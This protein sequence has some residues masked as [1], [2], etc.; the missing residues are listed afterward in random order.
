[1]NRRG[2]LSCFFT[3]FPQHRERLS[4]ITSFLVYWS[5]ICSLHSFKYIILH[6]FLNLFYVYGCAGQFYDNFTHTRVIQEEGTSAEKKNAP[7]ALV[8]RQGCGTF[9]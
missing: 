4:F 6:I 2:T 3:D 8:S 9:P 7:T 5:L 1:M